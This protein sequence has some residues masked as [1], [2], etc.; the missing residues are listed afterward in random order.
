MASPRSLTLF[1]DLN[2]PINSS[3]S[4]PSTPTASLPNLP[5]LSIEQ[6]MAAQS[7]I[8]ANHFTLRSVAAVTN[9]SLRLQARTSEVQQL[10]AQ[11]ALLQRM[12]K[13]A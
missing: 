2:D 8:E 6:I 1:S 3:G 11:L 12:Y 5:V 7:D 9:L 4:R 13:D 10:N